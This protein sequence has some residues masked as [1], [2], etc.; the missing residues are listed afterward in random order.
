M[1]TNY[2]WRFRQCGSCNRYEEIHVG[3]SSGTWQAYPHKLLNED[4]PDWGYDTES[5]VGFAVISVEDW[6]RVFTEIPGELW[7]ER[8][9]LIPDP[10]AWLEAQKPWVAGPDGQRYLDGDIQMGRG[11]LDANGF[12]FYTGEFW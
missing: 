1:G 8:K 7:T 5:P 4:Y 9:E 12:R 6:R 2:Y 11:W 3:K 10:I